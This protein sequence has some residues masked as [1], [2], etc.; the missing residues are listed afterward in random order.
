MAQLR[1]VK[2]K[3]IVVGRLGYGV[4]LLEE[5]TKIAAARGI[6][7]ARIDAIGAVQKARVGFYNQ[8][9][10]EYQYHSFGRP[11]E[12]TKLIGNISLKD[13]NPFVHAHITLADEAGKCYGGHLA[14]GTIVFACEF[15]LEVFDGPAF[16]RCPDEETG[17]SLWPV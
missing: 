5:L 17:L 4:D 3:E 6:R 11:M 16:N 1:D 2:S 13:D 15:I 14:A 12:I 9:R 10:R 7:L 8:Q